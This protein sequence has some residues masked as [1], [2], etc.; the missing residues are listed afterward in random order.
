MKAK[1]ILSLLLAAVLL[2]S[3]LAMP[4]LAATAQALPEPGAVQALDEQN[5]IVSV[6]FAADGDLVYGSPL[7]LRVETSP[8]DTQYIGVIIGVGGEA[9]GFVTL[10]FSE[11]IRIL[12][13]LIPLPKTMS[14]TPDQEE[15]F[16]VYAYLKQLIDGHDVSVLVRVADEVLSVMEALQF[17]IPTL[18]DVSTGL[19]EALNLI[20]RYLPED[21]GTRIYLDE[22]PTDSG[23]YVAGALA[24]ESGD[25]NTA[26]IALFRIKQKS[27]NV[28]LYWA[29]EAPAGGMT[30]G[31]WQSFDSA[32]VLESDGQPVA[33]AK[34]TY[35]YKKS[36]L[37]SSLWGV[38]TETVPTAPGEYIQTATAG[39]N[40]SCSS[41]SRTIKITG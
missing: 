26:G 27:E 40:Y 36:G 6:R 23:N 28:R 39:G 25:I 35:T 14:A 3:T 7:S 30:A 5:D 8:E 33:S 31:E 11:K 1:R 4:A 9:K 13:K 17:Y 21:T 41:I 38:A 12:L 18:K 10:T 37:F 32:A 16:N 29:Q 20:H 22:Q 24:L 34:V 2:G 19:Q 15:D